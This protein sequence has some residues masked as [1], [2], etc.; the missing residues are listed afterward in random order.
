MSTIHHLPDEILTHIFTSGCQPTQT[1]LS[2]SSLTTDDLSR[3]IFVAEPVPVLKPFAEQVS[4]VCVRWYSLV[5]ECTSSRHFWV[6]RTGFSISTMMDAI[7]HQLAKFK[8]AL[9]NA[10]GCDL[11]IVMMSADFFS[12][13]NLNS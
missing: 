1:F 10:E 9:Q 6:V 8:N 13:G 5:R 11:D 7:D 4:A 3:F 2:E 12:L